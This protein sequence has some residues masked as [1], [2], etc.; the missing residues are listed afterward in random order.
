L[1]LQRFRPGAVAEVSVLGVTLL[2]MTILFGRV[3]AQSSFAPW[4]EYDKFTLVWLLAGYGFLASVLP[5]WM[6]LVP[7]GYLSTF[8]KLGVVLLLGL[9]VVLMAPTIEMPRMTIFSAGG[10]PIIPGSLFPF[11]FITIACGAV[12]GFHALV[13]SGTTPKMIEQESQAVVGYAAMLLESFVGVMALIGAG[14]GLAG[15]FGLGRIAETQL[16]GMSGRDPLVFG[17]SFAV[18]ALVVLAASWVPA[19]RASRAD[20]RAALHDGGR[21]QSDSPERQRIRRVFDLPASPPARSD[22]WW[23][24]YTAQARNA[25]GLLDELRRPF[26]E[27]GR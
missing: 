15:A 27:A 5:A 18:L 3:V 4:F 14:V 16:Y 8:M 2:I 25:D 17:S 22:P 19:W 12:S 7:R 26:L 9:G 21:A 11:L 23:T 10:G 20:A 1:Y 24:Y 6:L 13:S